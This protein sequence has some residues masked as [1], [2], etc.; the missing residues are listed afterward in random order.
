MLQPPDRGRDRQADIPGEVVQQ[1]QGV[2]HH[3]LR[4]LLAHG[5]DHSGPAAPGVLADPLLAADREADQAV[6]AVDQTLHVRG[7][8]IPV[9]RRSEHHSVGSIHPGHQR[10]KIIFY[11][12]FPGIAAPF[13]AGT[14]TDIVIAEKQRLGCSAVCGR[15]PQNRVDEGGGVAVFPPAAVQGKNLHQLTTSQIAAVNVSRSSLLMQYA[16][17]T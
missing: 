1:L 15:R 16:G 5:D 12:A 13:A 10:L 4:L 17:I 8:R 11:D 6:T 7:D 14:G 9:G 3:I 2:A